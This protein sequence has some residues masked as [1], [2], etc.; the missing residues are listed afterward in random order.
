[1]KQKDAAELPV[2]QGDGDEEGEEDE[3]SQPVLDLGRGSDVCKALMDRYAKSSAP[4]H[5]HLCASAAA[6]RSILQEEGL[7]LTPPGYF[8]AVITAIRDADTADHDAISALS[9]FLAILL[10][11]APARSLTPKMVKDAVLVLA[12][13]LRDPP[14]RLPTGAVRSMVKSLGGLVLRLD[15]EDWNE[16]K[17]PMEVLLSFTVDKRPKVRRCAQLYVK[18][19]FETLKSS[20]IIK[21]ASKVVFSLYKKYIS[22]LKEFCTPKLLNAPTLNELHKTEHLEIIHMLIILKLIA[23]NLSE[24]V[25]MKIISDVYRFL[26]SASSLL[27]GH[28]VGVVDALVEQIESKVLIAES[29]NIIS[30]L[31]SYISSSEKNTLDTTVSGL[32]TLSNLLNKLHDV[33]PTLWIGSLPVIF[34]SVKGYLVADSNPSEAVAEVLKDL[35]NVHIDLK[36]SMTGASKLCNNDEDVNPE[37]SAI[38]DLCSVFSNMLNTCKSPTEPMLDVISALFLRLGKTS[39]LFMKDILLKLAQCVITVEE[40]SSI[41]K[42]LQKCIGSAVIAMGLENVLSLVPVSFNGEKKTCSNAWLIPILKRYASGASL[43]YFM[44]HIVPLAKS[45]LKACDKVKRATLQGKLRFYA[46]EMWDLLPAFC[47]CPPDI[48]QSFDSLAKLLAHSVKDDSSLHETISISL[49]TLVNENMRVLGANQDVNRHASLKDI[50]DKSESF[51]IGYTKK[52]ASKNI[53]ALAS[54]S[55][56]LIQ[57]M[58]DV[59]LDSPPEKHAVL[60]EAIESLASLVKSE[61]LHRFFLSLLEKFDLLNFLSESKKLNEGDMID[62]NKETETEETSKMD[63]NKEKRCLVIDLASSFVETADENLV[64]TI[65]DFI[66]T[67]LSA[68]DYTSKTEELS[69]LRKILEKHSWF[70][71]VRIDDLIY[72]LQ[73]VKS[74]DDN[75]IEKLRL[76]CYHFLLVHVIKINEEKMN[77]KAFLILNE[78][79]LKLKSKKESR[80]LAYDTLLATSCSLKNSQFVNAQSDVQRLFVMVMGYLSSSSPHI[81]SGAISAL[82]LLIYNDA[83]FCLA[84]PNLIPSVLVLLQ[85]KSNEVI[86]AALGFVKVLVS[87][88]H[89]NNLIILVPDIL[90]GIL[91]W[92]SISKH[93]FRLKVAIILEILIRKSDYEAINSNVPKKYKDFVNSVVE[94]HRR[95][96]KAECPANPDAPRVSK[97]P[98]TKRG[99]KRILDDVPQKKDSELRSGVIGGRGKKQR[100]DDA[101]SMNVAA[102]TIDKGRHHRSINRAQQALQ[103]RGSRGRMPI[104]IPS[105]SRNQ[106]S[107]GKKKGETRKKSNC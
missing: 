68:T 32:K 48:S 94:G 23:P 101:Y 85:N 37:T 33:Q 52:T 45:I 16:V 91:P 29:D 8:A 62:V 86:K 36:L 11:V 34:I 73:G 100:S 80:K 51:P 74:Q 78:I 63:K 98:V 43:C 57:T 10:P 54:N 84:V 103:I 22:S 75:M 30:A 20:S 95:K 81:M 72:L 89:S 41:M 19:V 66:N 106:S 28:I 67:S 59:F 99:K 38:V 88:L 55:M 5:R 90:N 56:D 1:M 47:R 46:H 83:E 61:D 105:K 27:T 24:K 2:P 65:F 31:T 53:K 76:S 7:P 44:D 25:R 3:I 14:S 50:H 12:T 58:A 35:I 87:S 60:K 97:Y 40:D 92:S 79:I 96:K 21:K 9:A 71:S 17:L 4:Q 69:T 64:N 107:K 26:R 39:Y 13:F 104:R 42:H 6:M 82:S 49:Q 102:E 18:K 93:H 15:L 70:C 77:T